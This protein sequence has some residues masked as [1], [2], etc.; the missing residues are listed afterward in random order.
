MYKNTVQGKNCIKRYHYKYINYQG[1]VN[2]TTTTKRKSNKGGIVFTYIIALLCLIAGLFVPLYGNSEVLTER[3][4]FLHL[5]EAL[6][7]ALGQTVLTADWFLPF[8]ETYSFTTFGLYCNYFAWTLVIYAAITV[9][10]IIFLI[11]VLLCNKE[12]KGSA[13]CAYIIE[14]AASLILSVYILFR[15]FYTTTPEDWTNFSVLVAFGGT[16]LMLIIQSF[17]NKKGLGVCKF[18]LY[19]LS[20]VSVI[21]LFDI[22][23]WVTALAEPF[24]NMAESGIPAKIVTTGIPFEYFVM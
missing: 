13:V 18:F 2:M 19:L 6:N 1:D 24:N 16:L 7:L 5:P 11:P 10:G 14:V 22:S 17:F 23:L 9:I 3:M 8:T 12:G 15:M 4:L 20:A 21:M